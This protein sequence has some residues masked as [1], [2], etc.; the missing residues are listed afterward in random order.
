MPHFHYMCA[1][2]NINLK[3]YQ[4]SHHFEKNFKKYLLGQSDG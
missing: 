4:N 3:K 2:K 1:Q